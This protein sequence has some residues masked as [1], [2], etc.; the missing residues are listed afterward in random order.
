MFFLLQIISFSLFA[1][2]RKC[3]LCE[4]AGVL[5]ERKLELIASQFSVT[6]KGGLTLNYQKQVIDLNNTSRIKH[7]KL[8]I[9]NYSGYIGKITRFLQILS[10]P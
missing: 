4:F 2:K 6:K 8:N 3:Y 7:R 10:L 9:S 5:S 1:I